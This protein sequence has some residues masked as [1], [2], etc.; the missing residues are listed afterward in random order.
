MQ[1]PLLNSWLICSCY[2]ALGAQLQ[3]EGALAFDF[4]GQTVSLNV[5]RTPAIE[6]AL[7]RIENEVENTV[8]PFKK[9]LGRTGILSGDGSAGGQF[10]DTSRALGVLGLSNTPLTR[11]PNYHRGSW[12]RSFF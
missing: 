9:L 1:G 3:A 5:D 10:M 11:F 7:G 4:G 8:K 6:S 2:Y 12:M